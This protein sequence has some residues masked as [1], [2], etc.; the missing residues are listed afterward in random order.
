MEHRI[1][2]IPIHYLLATGCVIGAGLAIL[3]PL[4]FGIGM[5]VGIAIPFLTGIIARG[6]RS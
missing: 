4:G 6:I 5:F 2:S 3:T 1:K